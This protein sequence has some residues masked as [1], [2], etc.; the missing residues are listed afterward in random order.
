[1][2]ALCRGARSSKIVPVAAVHAQF[3]QDQYDLF[4]ALKIVQCVVGEYVADTRQRARVFVH[5]ALQR[6]LFF[7][8]Q[9]QVRKALRQ[10]IQEHHLMY[11]VEQSV[12]QCQ[13][14]GA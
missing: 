7:C 9:E 11:I 1:M 4:H 3:F 13:Y 8:L 6:G 12:Q 10:K 2:G 5:H 14:A